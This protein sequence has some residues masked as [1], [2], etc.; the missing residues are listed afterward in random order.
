VNPGELKEGLPGSYAIVT[1]D[2]AKASAE[3]FHL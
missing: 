1:L 2:G 3:I